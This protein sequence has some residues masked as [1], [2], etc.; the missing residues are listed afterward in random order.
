[1]TS[2][3]HWMS[4]RAPA[5]TP[6]PTVGSTDAREGVGGTPTTRR[7]EVRIKKAVRGVPIHL[8]KEALGGGRKVSSNSLCIGR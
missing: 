4:Y 8:R 2:F 7:E 3:S 5:T 6:P 1:M